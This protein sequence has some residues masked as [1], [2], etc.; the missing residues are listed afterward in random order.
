[1]RVTARLIE[2]VKTLPV[3]F[4]SLGF[5]AGICWLQ[6][7]ATLP[8]SVVF[9]VLPLLGALIIGLT[10]CNT[11][12]AKTISAFLIFCFF[13][14]IGFLWA[15]Y[16]AHERLADALPSEWES[17][18]IVVVGVVA[19]LP[20]ITQ[21]GLRFQFDV[22]KIQT[23]EASVPRHILISW[24]QDQ[25]KKIE[26]QPGERWQLTVRLKRP[27]SNANPYV[28]DTEIK[29]LERN[30]RAIGYVRH[31][32]QNRRLDEQVFAPS[33]LIERMRDQIRKRF[34]ALLP[35]YPYTGVLIAL[36]I[37]DQRSISKDQWQWFIQTGT[38]HLMAISGLHVTMIAGLAFTVFYGL[39]RRFPW[40]VAQ[41]PARK[42][43]LTAGLIIA[44][45]YVLLSGFAI[46]ARRAFI[47][48]LV[49]AIGLWLDRHVA[50]TS[51][52]KWAL[53]M[54][55]IFDPWAVTSPGFWLSFG[56]MAWIAY[57][58]IDRIGRLQNNQIR[59]W[60]TI[61]WVITIGLIPLLLTLFHQF[62]L[63]SP[64][65]NAFLI[66]LVSFAVVPPTVIS[67]IPLFDFLLVPAHFALTIGM[68]LLQGLNELTDTVWLQHQPPFWAIV[69]G[70]LGIVW[71]FLPGG[72]SLFITSGFPSRWLGIIAL[73]PLFLI[74]PTKPNQGE[75]WVTVLDVGQGL[76]IVA[77]TEKHTLVFDTGP[78]YGDTDSG[79]RIVVPFLRGAGIQHIDQLVISHADSDHSGGLSSILLAMPV[80]A[81]VSSVSLD[82]P[83][84]MV[85]P[86]S[87]PCRS[88]D[89]WI[90]DGVVFEFLYPLSFEHKQRAH[91]SK[92]NNSSCV[93]KITTAG[94]SLL[95]P[96]DIEKEAE[97]DLLKYFS[98]LLPSTV[99]IAPH[100][101][102]RTSSQNAFVQSVNPQLTLF[103][104]GYRNHL[105]H[106]NQAI[107]ERYQAI[108][109]QIM[110][111]DHQGAVTLQ[112]SQYGFTA[113]GWRETRPRYW[114][115]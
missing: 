27:H 47:M 4:K 21:R 70:L 94:G 105:K 75:L 81:I 63:V 30:I 102:S 37:G 62:S 74:P 18:D 10:F 22:E 26:I 58:T 65:A 48:L 66:P 43:A 54:V 56:A 34:N 91:R 3:H 97:L 88:G 73:F 82:H 108:G 52:L 49:I 84:L 12:L 71:L 87:Q 20:E 35:N 104:V 9:W 100:H 99:L 57:V 103:T 31:S 25:S 39:W 32:D 80:K 110:R 77:Q 92:Q 23:A 41:L 93:L 106:P 53:V 14:V 40:L 101:G 109:S 33:Y 90:W 29:F 61:Q 7:Q 68:T 17:R 111:S 50:I 89:A 60:I 38:S 51:L 86:Q 85:A 6:Q 64:I 59:N 36:A 76:A 2:T 55:L 115:Q 112:F 67:V 114:Y 16:N 107:V 78:R 8:E 69:V 95:I 83:V 13:I 42:F 15:A 79:E 46:P 5:V 1:M 24:Y 96:A 11:Q 72:N 28:A 45:G 98:H 113:K 44:L 19:K